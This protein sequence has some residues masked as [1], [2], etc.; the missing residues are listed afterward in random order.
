MVPISSDPGKGK[1]NDPQDSYSST[2]SRSSQR[3]SHDCNNQHLTGRRLLRWWLLQSG[4]W[5]RLPSLLLEENQGL[6][7]LRLLLEENQSLP[8][9]QTTLSLLHQASALPGLCGVWGRKKAFLDF[10]LYIHLCFVGSFLQTSDMKYKC[11]GV[12]LIDQ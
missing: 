11:V 6:G 12:R 4:L 5:L 7:P 9:I 2:R 1:N 3:F 8:L 10:S